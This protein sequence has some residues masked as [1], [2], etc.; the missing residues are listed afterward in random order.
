MR[1]RMLV[2][3]IYRDAMR[4][5]VAREVAKEAVLRS[6]A[7]CRARSDATDCVGQ[8]TERF[9]CDFSFRLCARVSKTSSFYTD[10]D[11]HG[12]CRI[13]DTGAQVL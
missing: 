1:S 7:A 8:E 6:L 12:A 13:L 5:L 11:R 2:G 4:E 3:P 10:L 9:F